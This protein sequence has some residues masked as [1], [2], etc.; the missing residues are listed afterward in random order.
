MMAFER[1]PTLDEDDFYKS[2]I[3]APQIVKI[4]KVGELYKS[5]DVEDGA[6]FYI[7]F[8]LCSNGQEQSVAFNVKMDHDK[9]MIV[10]PE[11][12]KL[13]PLVSFVSGIENDD[14]KC[15]KQDIDSTLQGLT[16][17]A[18]ALKQRGNRTW[19]KIIPLERVGE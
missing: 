5:D 2:L 3:K 10:I 19:H 7:D 17:K 14:I 8:V 15:Y 6:Y 1:V 4:A 18:K 9:K 11:G 13:Y 12:A 16:F